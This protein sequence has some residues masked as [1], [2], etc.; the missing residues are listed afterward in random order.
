MK[1]QVYFLAVALIIAATSMSSCTKRCHGGGWY[2]DRNLGY[3]PIKEQPSD[4]PIKLEDEVEN[5]NT[6]EP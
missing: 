3:A 5:C 4:A 1:K 6:A 2:G